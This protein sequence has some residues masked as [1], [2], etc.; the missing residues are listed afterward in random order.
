MKKT[1]IFIIIFLISN[2]AFGQ[3]RQKPMHGLQVNKIHQLG[4]PVGLWLFNENYGSLVYDLSGNGKT[5][6]LL[7]ADWEPGGVLCDTVNDN[8]IDIS[9]VASLL[10]TSGTYI[11]KFRSKGSPD[12]TGYLIDSEGTWEFAIYRNSSDTSIKW[13]LGGDSVTATVPNLW[14]GVSHACVFT[15]D[16]LQN[17][18]KIYVD[19][20]L[21]HTDTSAVTWATPAV[22]EISKDGAS[23]GAV[24]EF[25]TFYNRALTAS[26]I[27]LL[28]REPFCMFERDDIALMEAAIVAPTVG[29]QVIIIS[30]AVIPLL[31][32]IPV[33]IFMKRGNTR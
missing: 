15:W 3:L 17:I 4:D 8:E 14:D 9:G 1:T 20:I 23:L 16:T 29:G 12:T 31:L 21:V 10:G 27:A 30:K 18:R 5:G 28:Y 11:L 32:I 25:A 33:L 2:L 22:L 6:T 13:Y 26:E 7:D 24:V 19:G